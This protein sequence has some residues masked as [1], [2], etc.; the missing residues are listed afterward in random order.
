[1]QFEQS[2]QDDLTFLKLRSEEAEL[3]KENAV[4]QALE[5]LRNRIDSL[6]ISKPFTAAAGGLII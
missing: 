6:G 4:S 5:V 1:M 3:I 2:E